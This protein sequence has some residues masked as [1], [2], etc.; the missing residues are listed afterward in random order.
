MRKVLGVMVILGLFILSGCSITEDKPSNWNRSEGPP[1]G[2]DTV[3]C[4]F[5]GPKHGDCMQ[6]KNEKKEKQSDEIKNEKESEVF[7]L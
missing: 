2:G 1:S 5:A 4:G 7:A 3:I 6:P